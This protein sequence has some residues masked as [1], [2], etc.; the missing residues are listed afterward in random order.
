VVDEGG[1]GGKVVLDGFTLERLGS[2]R[3]VDY[4]RGAS[5]LV[6]RRC[7]RHGSVWAVSGFC[8]EHLICAGAEGV[9]CSF[10]KRRDPCSRS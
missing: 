3:L 4:V 10:S 9:L 8:Q 1:C 2:H 6:D 5:A 7:W